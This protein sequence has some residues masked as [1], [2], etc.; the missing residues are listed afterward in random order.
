MMKFVKWYAPYNKHNCMNL[1]LAKSKHLCQGKDGACTWKITSF[2]MN[3]K[4][5]T[6]DILLSQELTC[7][8]LSERPTP[9]SLARWEGDIPEWAW[10]Q[11]D[12][13]QEVGNSSC[14]YAKSK[15]CLLG[16]WEKPLAASICLYVTQTLA[17]E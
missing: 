1:F 14:S 6:Q 15:P 11:E 2:V 17:S 16:S 9:G 8:Q 13:E 10:G 4:E 7:N 3:R 5:R 12:M